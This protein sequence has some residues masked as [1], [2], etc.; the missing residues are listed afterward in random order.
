MKSNKKMSWKDFYLKYGIVIVMVVLV[1]TAS[2]LSEN[3]L[4][5]Q[6][7]INIIKQITPAAVMAIGITMLLVSG[8]IDLA[9][10]SVA[11]LSAC[12]S[13][14]VLAGTNSFVLSLLVA[15]VI[16]GGCSY[17]SSILI[18][19]LKLPPFIATLATKNIADGL[20]I[21][22]TG[23][24][25]IRGLEKLRWLSQGKLFGVVPNMIVLLAV[26][27]IAGQIIMRHTRF[28][29]Y[30]YAAGGNRNAAVASGIN[31]K[32][33]IRMTYL[34]SGALIGIVGIILNARM[35]ASQPAVGPGYEFDAITATVVGGTGFSGGSGSMYCVIIGSV[36]IGV[37]NNIMVLLGVDTSW[38]VV[39]KGVLI[40]TAVAL[41]I[42]TKNTKKK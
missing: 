14:S 9:A 13:A 16:A 6:N 37:I 34:V 3:F 10:G 35:M 8:E 39:V 18:T 29:L 1:I 7:L 42:A 17:F 41:D 24:R 25:S 28:G 22:Y 21:I 23:G 38:Q 5:P 27:L 12:I 36:I 31:I 15:I 11:A 32:R 4:Q 30:M 19:K 40:A 2:F 20:V 26:L 33:Q